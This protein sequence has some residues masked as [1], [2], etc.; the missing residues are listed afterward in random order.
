[1]VH[2][3]G[4]IWHNFIRA[5]ILRSNWIERIPCALPR[6][7]SVGR[8]KH[9]RHFFHIFCTLSCSTE[10]MF[11]CFFFHRKGIATLFF[12]CCPVIETMKYWLRK[13]VK[14]TNIKPR[15]TATTTRRDGHFMPL[16]VSAQRKWFYKISVKD[17]ASGFEK[18]NWIPILCY[19]VFSTQFFFCEST[20]V[21]AAPLQVQTVRRASPVFGLKQNA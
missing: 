2:Q 13:M 4:V 15:I 21:K 20:P 3:S 14:R 9:A 17:E 16:F 12:N 5:I 6:A 18:E 19:Y 10:N 8:E 11:F 1:M 7:A